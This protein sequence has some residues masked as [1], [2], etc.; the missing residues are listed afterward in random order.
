MEVLETL[1]QPLPLGKGED[2][3]PTPPV[4]EGSAGASGA[5]PPPNPSRGGRGVLARGGQQ[6]FFWTE[7]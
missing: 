3:P 4:R 2:P 7:F 5:D 6:F 1:P